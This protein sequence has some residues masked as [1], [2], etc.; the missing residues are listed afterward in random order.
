MWMI[1]A[2]Q[3]IS[4]EVTVKD[5]RKCYASNSVDGTMI[6]CWMIV[7]DEDR[8]ECEEDESSDCEDGDSHTDWYRLIQSDMLCTLSVWN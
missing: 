1:M 8:S 7:K 3:C 5:F 4:P 6:I 2:W